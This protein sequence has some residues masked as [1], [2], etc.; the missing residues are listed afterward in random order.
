VKSAFPKERP[1]FSRVIAMSFSAFDRFQR[2]K[3]EPYFSYIYCGVRDEKGRLSRTALEANHLSFLERLEKNGRGDLWEDYVA[4]VLDLP[5]GVSLKDTITDL[6]SESS[7]T[8]SSGQSILTYFISAALAYLKEDSLILFDEPEIHLH[9][10]AVASL[11]QLLQDLLTRFDSYAIVATHSPVVIQEVPRK[12]VI[13]FEREENVTS[14]IPLGQESFGENISELTQ[15]VFE[16]IEMPNF[17]K[18][19]LKKLASNRSFDEVL[20]LFENRLSLHA[21]AYLAS[22]YEEDDAPA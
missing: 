14:A 7:S 19:T 8:M 16:T 10:N 21:C 5:E 9:P 15:Q 3:P 1:L 6:K 17:Y 18:T 20:E 4:K 22:L 13:R 12:R 2:P 11:I